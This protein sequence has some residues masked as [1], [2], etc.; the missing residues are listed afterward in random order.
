MVGKEKLLNIKH[1]CTIY[2]PIVL[3]GV[4]GS[5]SEF[6]VRVQ[7]VIDITILLEFDL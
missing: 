2:S 1:K 4:D 6:A 5:L 7:A 3:V